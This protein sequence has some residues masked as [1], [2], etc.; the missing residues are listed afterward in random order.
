MINMIYEM[1]WCY[2]DSW[3]YLIPYQTCIC[4]RLCIWNLNYSFHCD[5]LFVDKIPVDGLGL[6]TPTWLVLS[7]G[8]HR[9]FSGLPW[10]ASGTWLAFWWTR[11]RSICQLTMPC[12]S[13]VAQFVAAATACH[14][15][16]KK[17][18]PCF[19]LGG[20][21]ASIAMGYICSFMVRCHGWS[22]IWN[23]GGARSNQWLGWV[24]WE[25]SVADS[26][27]FGINF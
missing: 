27:G 25:A 26:Q 9:Y 22:L 11:K 3:L 13:R 16:T 5:W 1:I 17:M 15:P 14:I 12:W 7:L 23:I 4:I 2:S 8:L 20:P 6:N 10:K 18:R 21:N 19:S 24:V